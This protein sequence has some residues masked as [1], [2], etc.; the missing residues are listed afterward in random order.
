VEILAGAACTV[1]S[2]AACCRAVPCCA[3]HDFYDT[4]RRVLDFALAEND[5]GRYFPILGICLGFETLMILTAGAAWGAHYQ[6][7][8]IRSTWGAMADCVLEPQQAPSWQAGELP[9]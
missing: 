5:A 2:S 4:A 1:V 6:I 7:A 8:P 3:G 9:S